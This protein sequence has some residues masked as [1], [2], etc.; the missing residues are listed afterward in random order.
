MRRSLYPLLLLTGWFFFSANVAYA[1]GNADQPARKAD[2]GV[3]AIAD[4]A[5]NIVEL[6][7][8]ERQWLNNHPTIRIGVDP[9]YPPFEFIDKDGVYRGM[10]PEYLKLIGNRLGV[11]FKVVPG[12][13][14]KQVVEGAK[15]GTVDMVPIMSNTAERRK[16]LNFTQPY[17]SFPV[18]VITQNNAPSIS[19]LADLAGKTMA[20]PEGFSD[21]GEIEN[22]HPSIKII[23]TRNQLESLQYVMVGRVDA[24]QG[25]LAVMTYLMQKNSINNLKVA[26]LSDTAG[27]KFAMGVRK[28]WPELVT[29]MNKAIDAITQETHNKISSKWMT[30]VAQGKTKARKINL[31]AREREWLLNHQK[32][33]VHNEMNWPPFNFNE[34]GNPKGYSIEYMN[35]LAKKLDID[36]EYVSGPSWGQFMDMMRNRNLDVMLN[37]IKTKDRSKY[38]KFTEPYVENPPVII[39]RDDNSSIRSFKGLFGKTVCIPRGFFYQELI[40]RNFPQISMLLLKSQSD[41]LKSVAFGKADATIGG[42]A[43]QD[44]LIRQN[45]L[46]NLKV[47]G[48]LPDKIFNNRLR[49][50]VRGD[51]PILRDILQ[52]AIAS[53]SFE[54][55][56]DI[57]KKWFV[58]TRVDTAPVKTEADTSATILQVGLGITVIIILLLAMAVTVK[59]LEGKNALSFYES[60]QIK[61]LGMIF[62]GLFLCI[63]VLSAWFTVRSSEQRMREDVGASLRTVLQTTHEA[64]QTWVNGKKNDVLEVAA[65]KRLVALVKKLLNVPRNR[66]DLL[67]S[68]ELA[69]VRDLLTVENKKRGYYGF[70]IISPDRISIASMRDGN[71]GTVNLIQKHR[72]T[73]LDRVFKGEAVLIPPIETDVPLRNQS[74]GTGAKA[75]TMFFAAP[76]RNAS[77]KVVAVLTMR[78]DPSRD[79]TR[80]IQLGQVGLTGETYAFDKEGRLIS[81]SRFDD[82]LRKIGLIGKNEKAILNIY[83]HDP[84]GNLLQGYPKPPNMEKLPNTLM[85]EEAI[86]G[87]Q[88][89]N[90]RGYRDYRGVMVMGAWMWDNDMGIGIATEIDVDDALKSFFE[91]RNTVLIVLGATVFMALILTGLSI[92]IGQSANKSLRKARDDLEIKV[93]ER[94]DELAKRTNLLQAVMGSMTQGIVAFDKN[95]KL[96]SWNQRYLDIRG[97]PKEMAEEGRPFSDF[98]RYDI[99]H[100]EFK[101][102]DRELNLQQQIARAGKFEHHDFERQRQDGTFIEVRG[103]PIPGGGFV[104]TFNDITERKRAE[105]E[106]KL[107]KAKAES[108]T[109]AK[110]SFLAAMSHEIRTPMNGVI[111]MIDLL[112]ETRLDADQSRMMKTVRDSAFS[113]LHIINDILDFSKIEAGKLEL[114]RIP[115]SLRDVIEGVADTLQP[116][117]VKKDLKLNIFIDPEIPDWVFGDQVRVRQIL[118]NLGGNSIKFTGS[119]AE[120]PGYVMIRAERIGRKSKKKV[121]VRFSVEDNGI[122]MSKDAVS[123]LFKPFMQAEGSTTRRFGGTGLGLSICKNLTDLMKGRIKVVSEEGKGS[124]FIVELPFDV[125]NKSLPFK[126]E[127][128]LGGK[129]IIASVANK[130][131][132]QIIGNYLEHKGCNFRAVDDLDGLQGAVIEAARSGKP[133]DAVIIGSSWSTG[134]QEETVKYLRD[135]VDTDDLRFIIL[136][137]DRTAK[138]GMIVP[139]KV[140]VENFPLRRS[141]FIHGVAMA[142]GRA[143]PHIEDEH[144]KITNGIGTAPGVEEALAQ[145]RLILVAEDNVTNQDVIRRQLNV[146]GY[147]CE[148]ADDGNQA[149]EMIQQ[150]EYAVLLTDCHMPEMDG[151]ELTGWVRKMEKDKDRHMPIV[152]ITANALQG[153]GDR[154]LEVG[155]DDYLA[156]PLEMS[157]LKATLKKWMTAREPG[158]TPD[159]PDGNDD[160]AKNIDGGGGGPVDPRALKDMFGDDDETFR[161]ILNDFVEPSRAIV[162]DI[163]EAYDNRKNQDIGAAAHKLKSSSR[164][165]G[166]NRLADL[167]ATLEAAGKSGDW[168]VLDAEIPRLGGLMNAV[169]EY[170]EGL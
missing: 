17:L 170:I 159:P 46:T 12:L 53:V 5:T 151:Y 3:A 154:C 2:D 132:G 139:D 163:E 10:A 47:V 63:V 126:D 102:D 84:G 8:E 43:I 79:F 35:I 156:K 25:N 23:K 158:E 104:S 137:E 165:V 134:E 37:I 161:E 20:I 103:G 82:D 88:G 9:A 80:I 38:I 57:Q 157:K 90:V 166:A 123:N 148:I 44:Y 68:R 40:K 130:D 75:P 114:E 136:T 11:E 4:K 65:D 168:A 26:S 138:K 146:L 14:W 155:M 81:E 1:A 85:A 153:E 32:I 29:I 147:A 83:M 116:N 22:N 140:V 152:A 124:T 54:E 98:M 145:G 86:A 169:L 52:K 16:F 73:F 72:K 120:N 58:T 113:L 7:A 34:N 117:A 39:V 66:N 95:L 30:P 15:N 150:K 77:G 91:I 141:S 74:G 128:D 87:R 101:L 21:I 164:S 122:G 111:G 133:Y 50:G 144:E 100:G 131:V 127:P 160:S 49:I 76:L 96:I 6:T 33:R 108:A 28:D 41:C 48:G 106:L 56:A 18:V 97:Y 118:F 71:V 51:W 59:V 121:K 67:A 119:T 93:R 112:R 105:V 31:T 45:L 55:T 19:G 61:G 13:T 142:V 60:R 64:L 92:W 89:I 99:E 125:D 27:G 143:S 167:C 42:I 107:A 62:V 69:D 129:N 115:I 24:T 78:V 36:V 109:R 70:F 162:K 135:A 110:A 149:L 94:T